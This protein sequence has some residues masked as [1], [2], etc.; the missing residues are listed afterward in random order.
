MQ[1]RVRV[2]AVQGLLEAVVRAEMSSDIRA[3]ASAYEE[4]LTLTAES[5]PIASTAHFWLC[6]QLPEIQN[7][8]DTIKHCTIAIE[9]AGT[10][11]DDPEN[12][13]LLFMKRAWGY[14][15]KGGGKEWR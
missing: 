8:N 2:D 12:T 6:M 3:A 14:S 11:E 9:R 10:P 4:L 15:E 5:S 13:Y 1:L 7:A